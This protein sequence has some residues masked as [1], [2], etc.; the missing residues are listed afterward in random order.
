MWSAS[1]WLD[2]L[3]DFTLYIFWPNL[4]LGI[5]KKYIGDHM[6]S[7]LL[8]LAAGMTLVSCAADDKSSEPQG[9]MFSEEE[10]REYQEKAPGCALSSDEG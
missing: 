1:I 2:K 8:V 7:K 9:P 5:E 10:I 4:F 6:Y 3:Y